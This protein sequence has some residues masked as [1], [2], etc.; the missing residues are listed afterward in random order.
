MSSRVVITEVPKFPELDLKV[1][2]NGFCVRLNG[3]PTPRSDLTP[4]Q[5][6]AVAEVI[7][8]EHPQHSHL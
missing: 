7:K 4:E 3:T 1:F 5:R 8:A 6:K 2:S